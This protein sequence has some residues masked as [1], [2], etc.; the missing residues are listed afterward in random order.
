M[1]A[2][3][4]TV[5]ENYSELVILNMF[6]LITKDKQQL[7]KKLEIANHYNNDEIILQECK[8]ASKIIIAWGIDEKYDA[9]RT[10]L[11]RVNC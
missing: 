3:N 7:N 8:N 2:S 11:G 4:I 1:L 6:P 10:V 9:R 5:K